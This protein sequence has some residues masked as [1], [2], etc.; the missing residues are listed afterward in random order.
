MLIFT[1]CLSNY[2]PKAKVLANSVKKH[3]PDWHFCLVI[4]DKENVENTDNFFDEIV[5]FDQLN[6]PN[7]SQWKF[8]HRIVEICTAAKAPA[9][10]YFL[11]RGEEKVI[12]LDPDTKVF[13]SLAPLSKLLDKSDILLTPHI[14]HPEETT[15]IPVNEFSCLAHGIYNLGFFA[16]ANRPVG[17]K[18]A[19]WWSDRLYDYCLDDKSRGL[20]TDQK[21]CDFVPVFF[22]D[23]FISIDDCGYNVASWNLFERPLSKD[24][25]SFLARGK[26]LR[27]YHFTGY[28]SGAGFCNS[29]SWFRDMPVLK[30]MWD[31][32][33]TELEK[34]GQNNTK[35]KVWKEYSYFPNG[36]KISDKMRLLYRSRI[37]LMKAFPD[38]YNSLGFQKWLKDNSRELE[39]PE[40]Q[41]SSAINRLLPKNSLR[42]SV[43]KKILK[44]LSRS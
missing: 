25:D 3:H 38:P 14:L 23:S 28:D 11:E 7:F 9:L 24:R 12:Y 35:N 20:F 33:R 44:T 36:E 27:F 18:F 4:G 22:G 2:L 10:K 32:Y 21:W 31:D 43:A 26:P 42:R 34:F 16:V 6:I 17:K 8:R 29:S 15:N 13:N 1:S 5:S 39:S 30:E 37:D 40:G 41:L 19:S